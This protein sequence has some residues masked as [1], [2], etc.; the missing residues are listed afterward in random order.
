MFLYLSGTLMKIVICYSDHL[1]FVGFPVINKYKI[2]VI[3]VM[4][5]SSLTTVVCRKTYFVCVC[6]RNKSWKP[7]C[8]LS[9]NIGWW[10][11]VSYPEWT[12]Y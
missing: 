10:I 6:L 12:P 9:L 7:E 3:P 11:L 8:V 1:D 2:S 4:F 5:D